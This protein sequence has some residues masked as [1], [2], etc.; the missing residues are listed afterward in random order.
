[1][2]IIRKKPS[3]KLTLRNFFNFFTS[4]PNINRKLIL[5]IFDTLI[6]FFQLSLVFT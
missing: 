1:M 4:L 3:I 6:I 5:I 2:K